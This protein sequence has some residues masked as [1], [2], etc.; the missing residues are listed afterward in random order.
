MKQITKKEF[1]K[2]ACNTIKE[3]NDEELE[4]LRRGL[5]ILYFKLKDKG[6][7]QFGRLNANS[8]FLL[9]IACQSASETLERAKKETM[10]Y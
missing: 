9:D 4:T 3:L 5:Y 6:M 7:L 2:E 1:T 8:A 10:P